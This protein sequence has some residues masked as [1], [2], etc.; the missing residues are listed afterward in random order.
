MHNSWKCVWNFH[1]ADAVQ[2]F[3]AIGE[4]VQERYSRWSRV[5]Q[6]GIWIDCSLNTDTASVVATLLTLDKGKAKLHSVMYFWVNLHRIGPWFGGTNLFGPCRR[7][8]K[9][10]EVQMLFMGHL[11]NKLLTLNLWILMQLPKKLTQQNVAFI[12]HL[13]GITAT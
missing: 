4:I 11:L 6:D 9:L 5:D 8:H 13:S 12:N 1:L 3:A 7:K 10:K 2:S